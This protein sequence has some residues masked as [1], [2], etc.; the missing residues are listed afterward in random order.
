MPP[1]LRDTGGVGAT[2]RLKCAAHL[3]LPGHTLGEA[4]RGWQRRAALLTQDML[5]QQ[6]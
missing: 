2:G 5:M 4:L 3:S 6:E 1:D